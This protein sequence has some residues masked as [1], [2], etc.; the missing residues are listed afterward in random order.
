ML[1]VTRDQWVTFISCGQVAGRAR[2]VLFLVHSGCYFFALFLVL[3]TAWAH[4]CRALGVET[5]LGANAG[6]LARRLFGI[7]DR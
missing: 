1:H 5:F 6:R 7:R 4:G 3:T 2:L